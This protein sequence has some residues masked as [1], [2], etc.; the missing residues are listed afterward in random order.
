MAPVTHI[1]IQMM[2]LG[3]ED[4]F[5][6]LAKPYPMVSLDFASIDL[7]HPVSSKIFV[8]FGA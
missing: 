1:S 5:L 8:E 6:K 4:D 3:L 7:V 2:N